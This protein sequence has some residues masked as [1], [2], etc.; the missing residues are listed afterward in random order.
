[1]LRQLLRW[2]YREKGCAKDTCVLWVR[3]KLRLGATWGCG[4]RTEL[5]MPGV[6][7]VLLGWGWYELVSPTGSGLAA[8]FII[9]L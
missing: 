9:A 3:V 7:Q 8:S 4:L 2:D 5:E 6:P 1:M